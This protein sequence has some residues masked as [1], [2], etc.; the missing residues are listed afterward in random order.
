[1]MRASR[2]KIHKDRAAASHPR[3]ESKDAAYD[4]ALRILARRPHSQEEMRRKLLRRGFAEQAIADALL[5]LEEAGLLDDSLFSRLFIEERMLRR[6]IGRRRLRND[7]LKRGVERQVVEENLGEVPEEKEFAVARQL[8]AVKM[9]RQ[10]A[11]HQVFRFLLSRGYDYEM[12]SRAVREAFGAAAE[13]LQT[14]GT[15]VVLDFE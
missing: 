13:G 10:K 2:D 12:A 11:P 3:H 14:P 9:S 4:A 15:T 5:R 6:G 1:M 7:L 8:A